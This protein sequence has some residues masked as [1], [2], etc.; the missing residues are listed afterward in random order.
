M[1][2]RIARRFILR[3]FS[4]FLRLIGGLNNKNLANIGNLVELLI[5]VGFLA[6]D[7]TGEIMQD[8]LEFFSVQ[9]ESSMPLVWRGLARTAQQCTARSSACLETWVSVSV[10]DRHLPD[11][12]PDG[13]QSPRTASARS[14]APQLVHPSLPHFWLCFETRLQIRPSVS[15]HSL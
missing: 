13:V 12:P 2:P 14:R 4:P 6:L 10:T 5:I 11:N 3:A 9:V 7:D 15:P 1:R 8:C